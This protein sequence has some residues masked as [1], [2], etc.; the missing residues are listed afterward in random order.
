[1][2]HKII[3]DEAWQDLVQRQESG[4]WRLLLDGAVVVNVSMDSGLT[5]GLDDGGEIRA[6]RRIEIRQG[7]S[8]GRADLASAAAKDLA[9]SLLGQIVL[10]AAAATQCDL[11][12]VFHAHGLPQLEI[13]IAAMN[14]HVRFANGSECFALEGGGLEIF[15]PPGSSA[16]Q[17]KV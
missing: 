12:V 6:K 2:G 1:M 9:A 7:D 10:R 8:V 16:V 5:L 17:P 4:G 3:D 13:H 14:W 11:E 15:P